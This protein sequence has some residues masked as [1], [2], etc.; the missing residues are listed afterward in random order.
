MKRVLFFTLTLFTIQLFA[1]DGR[2]DFLSPSGVI[3]RGGS[4]EITGG[5]ASWQVD[6]QTRICVSFP[7][8]KGEWKE[9]H[10]RLV[11]K[12]DGNLSLVLCANGDRAGT[13]WY[14][15]IRVTGGVLENGSFEERDTRG[16]AKNWSCSPKTLVSPGKTG[17]TA[18]AANHNRDRANGT[19]S[20]VK[21][22]KEVTV[23]FAVK[24]P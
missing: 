5:T 13:M 1:A 11:P 20:Q 18:V 19:V 24:Q 4:P 22:G 15:D 10:I 2:I 14:D 23:T 6:G 9:Y 8:K 7:A 16:G 21:A 17:P 12:A 3:F